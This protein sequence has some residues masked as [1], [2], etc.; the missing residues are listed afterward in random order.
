MKLRI[1][2]KPSTAPSP[3]GPVLVR[4]FQIVVP[5]RVVLGQ[6]LSEEFPAIPDIGHTHNLAMSAE[7]LRNWVR[8]KLKQIGT[9]KINKQEV[10]IF[11][12]HL[13]FEGK[14][15]LCPEGIAVYPDG[16]PNAPRLPVMGLRVIARNNVRLLIE[17][18]EVEIG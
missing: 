16:H 3:T 7:H 13:Q 15:L 12:A 6:Q 10:S 1:S 17:N 8:L 4:P 14:Q 2:D 11:G 5:I 18:G 9:L